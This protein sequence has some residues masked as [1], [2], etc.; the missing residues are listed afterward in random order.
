MGLQ[1]AGLRFDAVQ[2]PPGV[3]VALGFLQERFGLGERRGQLLAPR[4]RPRTHLS[5]LGLGRLP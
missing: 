2:D 5:L 1:L 4:D 3:G